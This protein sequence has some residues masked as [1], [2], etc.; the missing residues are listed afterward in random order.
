MAE[1]INNNNN[2]ENG[3]ENNQQQENTPKTY[4][5]EEMSLLHIPMQIIR[6]LKRH[7]KPV[8]IMQFIFIMQCRRFHIVRQEW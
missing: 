5:E 6:R 3:A 2:N 7:L 1:D 8:Q 4:T